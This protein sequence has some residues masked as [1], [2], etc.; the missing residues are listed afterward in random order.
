MKSKPTNFT[1]EFGLKLKIERIKKRYTQEEL[2]D[3]AGISRAAYG[4]IERGESSPTI[5]TVAMLARA[6]GLEV[7]QL[8]KFE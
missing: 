1:A 7:W 4:S 8:F 3:I 6:L 5:D 2:A